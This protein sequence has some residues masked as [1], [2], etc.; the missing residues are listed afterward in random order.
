[1]GVERDEPPDVAET[2]SS[3]GSM[4][5]TSTMSDDSLA[6]FDSLIATITSRSLASL[7][8]GVRYKPQ[9]VPYFTPRTAAPSIFSTPSNFQKE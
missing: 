8:I 9:D 7:A 4:S 2:T 3:T 5:N 6:R 1:M